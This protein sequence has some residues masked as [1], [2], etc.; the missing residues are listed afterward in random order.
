MST[1]LDFGQLRN[2]G[3]TGRDVGPYP[4]LELGE[5]QLAAVLVQHLEGAHAP[6]CGREGDIRYGDGNGRGAG[7]AMG[8]ALLHWFT[9]F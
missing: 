3:S 8:R 9:P 2:G 1:T 4:E 7:R 5:E 6:R